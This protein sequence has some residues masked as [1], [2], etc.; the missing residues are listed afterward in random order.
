MMILSIPPQQLAKATNFQTSPFCSLPENS[1]AGR[2]EY[3]CPPE[4]VSEKY[5]VWYSHIKD[6]AAAACMDRSLAVEMPSY[7]LAPGS[8]SGWLLKVLAR[9]VNFHIRRRNA[10]WEVG[11]NVTVKYLLHRLSEDLKGGSPCTLSSVTFMSKGSL[12]RFEMQ[13]EVF[14]VF[15]VKEFVKK[16]RK[17]QQPT[18]HFKDDCQCGKKNGTRAAK[19][20]FFRPQLPTPKLSIL[21]WGQNAKHNRLVKKIEIGCHVVN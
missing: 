10:N 17:L 8:G 15:S 20:T 16:P 14:K 2:G 21:L 3:F 6:S 7:I 5:R 12:A 13:L 19:V 11:S 4:T 1:T 9:R 18:S